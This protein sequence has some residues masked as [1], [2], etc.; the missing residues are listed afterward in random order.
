M[1]QFILLY[2]LCLPAYLFGQ[3][4]SET[5]LTVSGRVVNTHNETL[6]GAHV[7][8][9][10]PNDTLQKQ[11]AATDDDGKFTIQ[12]PAGRYEMHISYLGHLPFITQVQ[13][14]KS[15]TLP[16]IQLTTDSKQ[17]QTVTVIGKSITYNIDGYKAHL[18]GNPFFKSHTLDRALYFLPGVSKSITGLTIYN[19]PIGI[20]YINNRQIKLNEEDLENYL[21][22]FPAS[23]IKE[24]QVIS[25]NGVDESA[26]SGGKAILRITTK[27]IEDG[28]T[29]NLSIDADAGKYRRSYKNPRMNVLWKSGNLSASLLASNF[30][31]NNTSMPSSSDSYFT[32]TGLSSHSAIRSKGKMKY[33]M[34][35]RLNVN[36]DFSENDLLTVEASYR[37]INREQSNESLTN[38][39]LENQ[40]YSAQQTN[41]ASTF[42]YKEKS[43]SADYLRKWK[44]GSLRALVDYYRTNTN[45]GQEQS[46]TALQDTELKL[47]NGKR[48]SDLYCAGVK[49]EQKLHKWNGLLKFGNSYTHLKTDMLTD[50]KHW[51]ALNN[52]VTP[53]TFYDLY[54]YKEQ[55]YGMYLN[56][57]FTPFPKLTLSAG[58]RYEYVWLSPESTINPEN[59]H[60]NTYNDLFPQFRV[61]YQINPEKGH[62]INIQYRRSTTRPAMHLLN[63]AIEWSNEYAYQTGNPYLKPVF[64]QDILAVVTLFN[65][66]T[67]AISHSQTDEFQRIYKKEENK[68]IYYSTYENGGKSKEWG[69]GLSAPIVLS[70]FIMLNP[71]INYFYQSRR[72]GETSLHAH[73]WNANLNVMFNMPWDISSM[74]L[75]IYNAPTR[76]IDYKQSEFIS[77]TLSFNK[78]FLKNRLNVG[79]EFS[80]NPP[81]NTKINNPDFW[82]N[83]IGNKDNSLGFKLSLSYALQWGKQVR[84]RN[85]EKIGNESSR[86]SE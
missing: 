85:K 34:N 43:L 8:F 46:V 11:G 77:S 73:E 26:S 52:L 55:I 69:L 33:S 2:L 47:L 20:V 13:A 22:N 1:K 5:Q 48:T 83:I 51:D 50:N 58:L 12:L 82:Q 27:K 54:Q 44:S 37:G 10:H 29:L 32:G 63:P 72:Y 67:L 74:L 23:Q 36:Y 18:E 64:G 40:L 7:W 65:S 57:Q 71:G 45:N 16:D 38:T 31:Y 78:P 53:G 24:V 41:E 14:T 60:S 68:D 56:Y 80:Y 19:R 25:G 6:P 35:Y 79:L 15:M 61:N 66:Y 3:T 9:I 21:R 28:G 49:V 42:F 86:L 84:M 81:V 75:F 62:N 39:Y 17:L 76:N 59:N 70:S 30:S 4:I